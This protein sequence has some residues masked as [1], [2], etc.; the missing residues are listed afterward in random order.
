MADSQKH[1]RRLSRRDALKGSVMA[2][3]ISGAQDVSAGPGRRTDRQPNILLIVCDQ[4]RGDCVGADGNKTIR[5]PNLDRLAAEGAL[6]GR[7]YSSLPSCTPARATLLTGLGA[8]RH[9]M[10]GYGRVARK[11]ANEMPQMLRQ[12]GYYGM[13]IGKMHWYPQRSLHGFHKTLVDE[14]GRS[15][16]KGFVSDYRQWFK[17]VAGDLDPDATGVG[18]NDYR[19][20]PYALPEKFHPTRWTADTAVDFLDGYGKAPDQADKPFFLK[21]SFARPHSPYDPP[22]RFFD[23]YAKAD[24]PK[25]VVGDW[26][27]PNAMR[28]RKLPTTTPRGDLGPKQVRSSRQGY[29]G[30]I[31]FLDEQIGRIFDALKKRRWWDETLILFTSDHGDMQGDHHLW[32]KTYA[33]EGSARVPMLIRWPERLLTAKRGQVLSQPAE[34]RDVLPTFLDAAGVTVDQADFDGR[35]MLDLIRGKTRGWRKVIDLEHCTCYWPANQWCALTDGHMKYIYGAADGSEQLF[36]LDADP[37]ETKDLAPQAGHAAALGGWRKRMVD[38]LA[39]RGEKWVKDGKLARRPKRMLYSPNYP[40]RA[41]GK[42]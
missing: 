20:K 21:V 27:E 31:T 17:T 18:W 26:A 10:L 8:W 14:S 39:E 36:D 2:A 22:R 4:F 9:G 6:F 16:T 30:A 5:T 42:R 32:R 1:A 23:M 33:Y 19:A 38:H 37:G 40:G 3:V 28:G 13:G 41:P 34:L 11:Y 12:A 24:I 7:A 35:S 25:A 15:E 29:Y